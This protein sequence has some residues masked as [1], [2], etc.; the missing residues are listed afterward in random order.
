M[1]QHSL[2]LEVEH[3][4]DD[5]L[6]RFWT[7]DAAALG[8]VPDGKDRGL[9][10]LCEPHQPCGALTH[11]A[12]VSRRAL[13][14]GSE[15]RLDRIDDDRIQLLGSGS[16]DDRLEERLIQQSDVLGGPVQSF[17]AQL[18]LERRLLSGDIQGGVAE[19]LKPTSDL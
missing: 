6:E 3:G 19:L 18:Y 17:R 9:G 12:N 16:G 8:D 2:A 11:L 4:I 10:L 15:D 13:E 14:I 5:V 1:L 7:G